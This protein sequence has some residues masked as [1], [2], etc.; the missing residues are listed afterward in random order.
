MWGEGGY[1]RIARG[2]NVCGIND[3]VDAVEIGEPESVLKTTTIIE[4][5]FSATI[6]YV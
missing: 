6:M 1:A 3:M 2:D 4:E 5:Q